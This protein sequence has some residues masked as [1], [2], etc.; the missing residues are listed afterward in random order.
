MYYGILALL[1]FIAVNSLR[2]YKKN[3]AS[4]A[5]EKTIDC[6]DGRGCEIFYNEKR[7]GIK[8]NFKKDCDTIMNFAI[9]F[10]YCMSYTDT[11][12]GVNSEMQC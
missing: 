5:T 10:D 11:K 4:K 6:K 7:Q 3:E 2:C 9:P 8:D 1:F 12:S